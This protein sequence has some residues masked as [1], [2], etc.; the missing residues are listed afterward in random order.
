MM[1]SSRTGYTKKLSEK[2]GLVSASAEGNRGFWKSLFNKQT[3]GGPHETG[4]LLG[5]PDPK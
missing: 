4:E 1:R 5:Q 3:R 2:V